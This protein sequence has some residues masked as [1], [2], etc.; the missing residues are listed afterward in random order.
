[1]KKGLSN[2]LMPPKYQK[3]LGS[4]D[5]VSWTKLNIQGQIRPTRNLVW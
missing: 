4:S 5:P 3:A 2:L 1:M